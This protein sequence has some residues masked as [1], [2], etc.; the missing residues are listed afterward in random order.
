MLEQGNSRYTQIFSLENLGQLSADFVSIYSTFH[1]LC[2]LQKRGQN[3]TSVV[4]INIY[5]YRKVTRDTSYAI[6]LYSQLYACKYAQCFFFF[7]RQR[8]YINQ[9]INEN[10]R[11]PREDS[12]DKYD[13]NR[14]S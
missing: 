13:E 4:T 3:G 11:I 6:D 1:L 2:C 9:R 7:Y 10:R 14:D 8:I 12:E 5:R